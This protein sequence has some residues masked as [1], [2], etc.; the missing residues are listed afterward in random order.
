[1]NKSIVTF[2][3]L[4]FFTATVQAIIKPPESYLLK[5]KLIQYYNSGRYHYEFNQAIANAKKCL[6]QQIHNGHNGKKPSLVLD[7]DDTALSLYY[8]QRVL[9]F[10][11]ITSEEFASIME[12]TNQPA[13]PATL[14]LYNF[15]KKH[16]LFVFFI[17]GRHESW[18]AA[19]VRSLQAAGYKN[20]DG[21]YLR[22]DSYSYPSAIPFKFG[23]RKLLLSEGYKI[24][25]NVGDQLSDLAGDDDIQCK[26]KLPNPYYFI[27]G[28]SEHFPLAEHVELE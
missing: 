16:G 11:A 15:A 14:N 13:I 9:G 22:P 3:C 28:Q 23:T 1:M 25:G 20:W 18:R 2:F 17:S 6:E 26:F 8:Y 12:K 7:I 21:L 4:I 10:G 27:A 24:I 19:T 5:Q